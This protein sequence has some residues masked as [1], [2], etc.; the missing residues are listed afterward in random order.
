MKQLRPK[1]IL[2]YGL[3]SSLI[4]NSMMVSLV[5]SILNEDYL[6]WKIIASIAGLS[7]LAFGV[8]TLVGMALIRKRI[9]R[10]DKK[11][12]KIRAA[13]YCCFCCGVVG[14]IGIVVGSMYFDPNSFT[15]TLVGAI[16]LLIGVIG[17]LLVILTAVNMLIRFCTGGWNHETHRAAEVA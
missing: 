10:F 5:V 9:G 14:V 1:T 12:Q 15:I 8:P 17:T 3:P 16:A 2:A 7:W 11:H 13:T 4:L 6:N